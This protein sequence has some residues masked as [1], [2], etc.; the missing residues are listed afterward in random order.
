M[1]YESQAK[2]VKLFEKYRP[3]KF[4]DILGQ[5]KAV[6]QIKRILDNRWGGKA[7]CI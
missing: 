6:Q 5:A 4:E 2:K 1:F 3:V 7:F